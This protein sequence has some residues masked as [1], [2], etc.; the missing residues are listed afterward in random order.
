MS[1]LVLSVLPSPKL[2]EGAVS[3]SETKKIKKR[4]L[5]KAAVAFSKTMVPKARAAFVTHTTLT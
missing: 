3:L 5:M 2:S 4:R 1:Q